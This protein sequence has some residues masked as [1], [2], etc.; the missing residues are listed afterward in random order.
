[1][2]ILISWKSVCVRVCVRKPVDY[3]LNQSPGCRYTIWQAALGSYI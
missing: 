3:Y 2:H 1:M